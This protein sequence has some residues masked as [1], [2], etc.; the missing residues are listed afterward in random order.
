[1]GILNE[2]TARRNCRHCSSLPGHSTN[3][4]ASVGGAPFAGGASAARQEL[5]RGLQG[6]HWIQ[7]PVRGTARSVRDLKHPTPFQGVCVCP[8]SVLKPSKRGRAPSPDNSGVGLGHGRAV[9][10]ALSES[11][12]SVAVRD[13][14]EVKSTASYKGPK[15]SSQDSHGGWRI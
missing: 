9:A 10:R 4:L 8:Q 1:M 15:F 11:L 5:R 7:D 2:E 14:S 6:L 12:A 3:S 13:S